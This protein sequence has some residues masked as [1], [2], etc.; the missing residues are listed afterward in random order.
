MTEDSVMEVD[1][2]IRVVMMSWLCSSLVLKVDVRY[3]FKTAGL[4]KEKMHYNKQP[5]TSCP[6]NCA[7]DILARPAHRWRYS[8]SLW[9]T[10]FQ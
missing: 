1:V 4:L 2:G 3:C 10:R 9:S 5:T 6:W 7:A 8:L